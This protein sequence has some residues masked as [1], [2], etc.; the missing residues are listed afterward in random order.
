MDEHVGTLE[1][2]RMSTK[3]QPIFTLLDHMIDNID[4]MPA[5]RNNPA[6]HSPLS[7]SLSNPFEKVQQFKHDII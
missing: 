6:R 4:T 7:T 1:H 2:R 3:L 5:Q